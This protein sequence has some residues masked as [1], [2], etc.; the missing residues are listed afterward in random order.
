MQKER[1]PQGPPAAALLMHMPCAG[2]WWGYG[3]AQ[4]IA[5]ET[6][7][8]SEK[9]Q[10][11]SREVPGQ[12]HNW[13]TPGDREVVGGLAGKLEETPGEGETGLH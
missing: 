1:P 4:G 5:R 6:R 3:A 8:V 12:R 2:L 13:A 10:K 9:M 7:I 11:S